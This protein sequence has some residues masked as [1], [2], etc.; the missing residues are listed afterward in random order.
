MTLSTIAAL[1]LSAAAFAGD[2]GAAAAAAEAEVDEHEPPWFEGGFDNDFFT[3]YIWRNSLQNDRPVWQPCVWAD[4]IRFENVSAGFSVWQNWDFTARRAGDGLQRAMNE[5]DFNV[6]LGATAWESEDENYSL[7]VEIGNEWYTYQTKCGYRSD[8]P[9][10]TEFYLKTKFKTPFVNWYGQYSQA[11]NPTTAAHFETGLD[12]EDSIGELLDSERD[13]LKRLSVGLDW[14]V[15]FAQ[16]KYMTD[17]LYAVGRP[18]PPVIDEDGEEVESDEDPD[19]LKNGIGGTTLKLNL[20][21]EVC[22]CF[23]F[24][25]VCAYTAVLNGEV[26]DQLCAEGSPVA[27]RELFWG[28]IQAKLS[29]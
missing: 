19:D 26:R 11:Y 27:S 5:T 18:Q 7:E 16:G 14:N 17:Y 23:T 15:N 9:A 1:S 2:D 21:Y 25:I 8:W 10:S 20:S 6:H 4:F 28:G 12:R 24:G 13:W 29:F 22:D 3:A